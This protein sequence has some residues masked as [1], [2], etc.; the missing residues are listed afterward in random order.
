MRTALLKAAGAGALLKNYEGAPAKC[1]KKIPRTGNVLRFPA[2]FRQAL[3]AE[4]N[5][6]ILLDYRQPAYFPVVLIV[7]SV[8]QTQHAHQKHQLGTP[9]PSNCHN[10]GAAKERQRATMIADQ[11]GKHLQVFLT[12]GDRWLQVHYGTTRALLMST[13]SSGHLAPADFVQH[14]S[15]VQDLPRP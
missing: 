4:H 14:G 8:C 12:P 13:M 2:H 6:S 10:V 3:H 5:R 15:C 1:L 9:L 11:R 7:E